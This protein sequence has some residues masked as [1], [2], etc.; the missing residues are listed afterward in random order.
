MT[1]VEKSHGAE[2]VTP[3]GKIYKFDSI[4]CMAAYILKNKFGK[5]KIHS[6]LVIDFKNP[7][8]FI[9]A[10]SATFIHSP[11]LR[12]PMAMN[13][14]AVKNREAGISMVNK[15]DGNLLDWTEILALVN[16]EWLRIGK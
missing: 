6:L 3:E 4:E 2:L 10:G 16:D 8:V 11:K 12:S 15:Y 1:I 13:L 9:D 14:T 7:G 5:E